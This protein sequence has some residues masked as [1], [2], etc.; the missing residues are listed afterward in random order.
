MSRPLFDE[1]VNRPRTGIRPGLKIL[2]LAVIVAIHVVVVYLLFT[3]KFHYKILKLPT[4]VHQVALAPPLPAGPPKSGGSVTVVGQEPGRK[5]GGTRAA[6]AA[7]P[8]GSEAA[9]QAGA[10]AAPSTG[11]APAFS[12]EGKVKP[13]PISP[14]PLQPGAP[15]A[16]PGGRLVAPPKDMKL[17]SYTQTDVWGRT[18]TP[19]SGPGSGQS[20][21]G[22]LGS[23]Y[24]LIGSG[25]GNRVIYRGAG[26]MAAGGYD[27]SPWARILLN[28]LQ[29]NWVLPAA[30]AA[31]ASGRVGVTIVV[32]KSGRLSSVRLIDSPNDQ[33]LVRAALDAI[34]RSQPLPKLP[35]DYPGLSL[36]AYLLFDYHESR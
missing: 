4:K 26:D 19:G 18:P 13:S 35:D 2:I 24:Q 16:F 36:E 5:A 29:Q 23:A 17:W 8:S 30:D 33:L 9:P 15:Q 31:K 7:A 11:A 32:E 12:L 28:L 21:G 6:A 10:L 20:P 14:T 3:S 25:K 22:P 27:I 34:T 1:I